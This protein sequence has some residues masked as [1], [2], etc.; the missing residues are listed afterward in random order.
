MDLNAL[1]N[2]QAVAVVLLAC[3]SA[4]MHSALMETLVPYVANALQNGWLDSS[5]VLD[6]STFE[7]QMHQQQY[8][9]GINYDHQHVFMARVSS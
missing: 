1:V 3:I 4:W 9:F 8:T 5:E 7:Q 2:R 6:L